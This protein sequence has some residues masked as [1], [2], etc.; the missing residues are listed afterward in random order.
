MICDFGNDNVGRVY[1]VAFV[2]ESSGA[3]DG[4][5]T[6]GDYK[7]AEYEVL[8]DAAI[9]KIPRNRP[10]QRNAQNRRMLVELDDAFMRAEADDDIRVVILTGEGLMFSS[11]HDIG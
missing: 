1:A 5:R 8:D 11:G 7:I 10:D 4:R 3:V 9:V 2:T 6:M